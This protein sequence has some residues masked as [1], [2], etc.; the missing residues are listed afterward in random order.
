MFLTKEQA[1][2]EEIEL[3]GPE[4]EKQEQLPE[5][6]TPMACLSSE[7]E[8]GQEQPAAPGVSVLD[9]LLPP[10]GASGNERIEDEEG[11]S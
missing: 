8:A 6:V 10:A 5:P 7:D 3:T 9:E 2:R 4:G 1:E 11:Q